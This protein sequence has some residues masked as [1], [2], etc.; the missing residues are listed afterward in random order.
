MGTSKTWQISWIDEYGEVWDVTNSKIGFAGRTAEEALQEYRRQCGI[1]P[2]E[3]E[4]TYV[5]ERN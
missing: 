2:D 1:N 5:V 4:K 3:D